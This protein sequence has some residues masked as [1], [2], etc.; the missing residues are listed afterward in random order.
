MHRSVLAIKSIL[1]F[2]IF[3]CVPRS[4]QAYSCMFLDQVRGL[5]NWQWIFVIDGVLTIATG[6]V[7]FV[8]L[9]GFPEKDTTCKKK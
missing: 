2:Y 3:L 6:I 1:Q 8:F 5:R 7:A 9:P 4:Q